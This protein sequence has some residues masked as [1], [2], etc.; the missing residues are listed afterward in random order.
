M[1]D[2]LAILSPEADTVVRMV[3]N[4]DLVKFKTMPTEVQRVERPVYVKSLLDFHNGRL[5]RKELQMSRADFAAY[6]EQ[7][8]VDTIMNDKMLETGENVTIGLSGGLDSIALCVLFERCKDRIP[9]FAPVAVTVTGVPEDEPISIQYAKKL[10]EKFSIQHIVVPREEIERI[11]HLRRPFGKIIEDMMTNPFAHQAVY[12]AHHIIRRTLED[13]SSHQ[14]IKK[15]VLGLELEDIMATV[16]GSLTTGYRLAGLN[17]R[18]IGHFT[19]AY[20]LGNSAKKEHV[21]YLMLTAKEFTDQGPSGPILMNAPLSRSL[22]FVLFDQMQE[23]WP[24]IDV[25]LRTA[26]NKLA[27]T[28]K[29]DFEECSNCGASVVIDS[30]ESPNDLCDVCQILDQMNELTS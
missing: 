1:H 29:L 25:H 6:V 19:Y 14:G 16:L 18:Q 12:C 5:S 23:I 17:K 30:T 8:F 9:K 26:Y 10:C 7:L 22:Y 15:I 27:A 2:D 13:V 28:E 24:G 3:T 11:F 4:Y 21:L 20:P